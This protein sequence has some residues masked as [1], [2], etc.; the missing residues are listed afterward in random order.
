M[1]SRGANYTKNTVQ[2]QMDDHYGRFHIY[3]YKTCHLIQVIHDDLV[4]MHMR[5]LNRTSQRVPTSTNCV[6]VS[7]SH[8]C[9][10]VKGAD[11]RTHTFISRRIIKVGVAGVL[12]TSYKERQSVC[13]QRCRCSGAA[14]AAAAGCARVPPLGVFTLW[15]HCKQKEGS[16]GWVCPRFPETMV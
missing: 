8:L 5:R 15:L 6:R 4:I 14:A 9:R 11:L 1:A 2:S 7:C 3:A 13:G 10:L 12:S 16:V